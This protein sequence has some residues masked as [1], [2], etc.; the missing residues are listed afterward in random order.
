VVI[1][2]AKLPPRPALGRSI[3]A[4][5]ASTGMRRLPV[6]SGRASIATARRPTRRLLSRAAGGDRHLHRLLDAL[7]LTICWTKYIAAYPMAARWWR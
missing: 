4:P 6:R 1:D 5:I 3:E 2:A 7:P